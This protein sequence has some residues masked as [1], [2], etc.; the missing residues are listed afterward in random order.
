MTT[1]TGTTA[2]DP[3]AAERRMYRY[4]VPIDDLAWTFDLTGNPVYVAASSSRYEVEFWAEY[5]EGAPRTARRFQVFGTGHPLPPGARYV[6]TCPR[7][8]EGFV[9]HLYEL[10]GDSGEP[11]GG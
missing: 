9:W 11:A 2:R 5:A 3:L 7:T 4:A 8:P 6:G 1:T 10:A